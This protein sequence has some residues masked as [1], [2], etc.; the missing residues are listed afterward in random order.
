MFEEEEEEIDFLLM[1]LLI[2]KSLVFFLD[3]RESVFPCRFNG[4]MNVVKQ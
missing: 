2:K 4:R 3:L 1:K